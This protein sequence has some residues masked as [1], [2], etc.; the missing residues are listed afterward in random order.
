MNVNMMHSTQ[1]I[2]YQPNMRS[3]KFHVRTGTDFRVSRH[4]N[5]PFSTDR[6]AYADESEQYV[7]VHP[8]PKML[9]MINTTNS[10][11]SFT[12]F[13]KT[14]ASL[15]SQRAAQSNFGFTMKGQF[16]RRSTVNETHHPHP[17]KGILYS[18][19]RKRRNLTVQEF[20]PNDIDLT[21]EYEKKQL[22]QPGIVQYSKV[23]GIIKNKRVHEF[24][25]QK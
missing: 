2:N 15:Q 12:L 1:R 19:L 5:S 4:N 3:K 25:R 23:A 11:Q 13:N 9:W 14:K 21:S 6:G 22:V 18:D 20:V 7:A 10:P 16:T 8:T 24:V 17:E